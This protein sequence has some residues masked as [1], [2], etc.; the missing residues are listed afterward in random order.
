MFIEF[1]TH[2][3]IAAMEKALADAGT[4]KSYETGNLKALV[5]KE[6]VRSSRFEANEPPDISGLTRPSD[7][8]AASRLIHGW[9]RKL[10]PS[11][12]ADGRLWTY[13]SHHTFSEYSV[14]RWGGGV[15]ESANKQKVIITRFFMRGDSIERL[16]RNS[17]GR[18]WWFGHVCFDGA[19]PDP[20]EFLPVLL[21]LQD[22][23]SALLERR[24]GMCRPLL[25]AVL[26]LVHE[27]GGVKGDV[28][29]EVG[30]SANF[31]GGGIVLDCLLKDE[32]K[33]RLR[34]IFK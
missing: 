4:V 30:R 23:Q 26:E 7:D 33:N 21:S 2:P 11:S 12:A 29:K 27:L 15:A 32:L 13:L 6:S 24:I 9:L 25:S 17:I 1:L 5:P 22:I 3:G 18:L 10:K 8:A 31:M 14:K 19:K 28:I 20:Y 16:F 34:P